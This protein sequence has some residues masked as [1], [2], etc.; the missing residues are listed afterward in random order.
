MGP[1][2]VSQT[3]LN[4]LCGVTDIDKDWKESGVITSG[5]E[6]QEDPVAEQAYQGL[7]HTLPAAFALRTLGNT[8]FQTDCGPDLWDIYLNHISADH[9]QHHN[10][11]ACR[12]F[13]RRYGGLVVVCD[14]GGLE[15][16]MWSLEASPLLYRTA[17]DRL[18]S[19]VRRANI[20]GVFLSKETTLGV[21]SNQDGMGRVW[22]HFHIRHSGREHMDGSR[23][24]PLWLHMRTSD[25][26]GQRSAAINHNRETVCR[27]LREFNPYLLDQAL[28]LFEGDHMARSEKFVGP[29]KWLRELHDLPAGRRGQNLLWRAVAT[30]PEGY[31]HPRSSVV[32]ELLEGLEQGVPVSE[33]RRKHA[34]MLRPL[35][36]QRPQAPPSA[37]TV[38]QAEDLFQRMGLETALERR[39]LRLDE[40]LPHAVWT[41]ALGPHTSRRPRQPGIFSNVA[42]KDITPPARMRDDLPASVHTWKKFR[43]EVLPTAEAIELLLPMQVG[44]FVA[45]VTQSNPG[46]QA[47]LKWLNPVNWY[48][49]PGGSPPAQWRMEPG[50][51]TRV[52]AILPFPNLWGDSPQPHY[53]YG[54]VLVLRGCEDR[55]NG[56]LALF[57]EHLRSELHPMRSVIEAFSRGHLLGGRGSGVQLASGYDIRKRSGTLAQLRVQRRGGWERFRI[58]RMD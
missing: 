9:R 58:D 27:A 15:P 3:G 25:T 8:V 46:A 6:R 31:C 29:V 12:H 4:Y 50:E 47:I 17:V 10:C 5:F 26:P 39:L 53:S 2:R 40:A 19:R 7:L 57:P 45:L 48:V 1:R 24:I 20:T 38:K 32:G 30:A 41:P 35:N 56:G 36:Y 54:H 11:S 51:W 55:H 49:Y 42:L 21:V 37:Q 13:V 33:L 34:A 22:E 14:D 52:E 44:T 16:V 28:R 43:E 18:Q 23:R